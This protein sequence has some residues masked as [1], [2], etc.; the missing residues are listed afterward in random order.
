MCLLVLRFVN[1]GEPLNECISSYVGQSCI[2]S[3]FTIT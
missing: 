1:A 3:C 2:N